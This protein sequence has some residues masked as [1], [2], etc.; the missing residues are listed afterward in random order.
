MSFEV[1]GEDDD[2]IRPVSIT[3]SVDE[4]RNEGRIEQKYNFLDYRFERDGFTVMARA[5]LDE[6]DE[7]TLHLDPPPTGVEGER[8][9][10]DVMKYLGWRYASVEVWRVD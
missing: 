9:V 7:V 5:Y 10:E 6:I 8:F 2:P 3:H 1:L 4:I